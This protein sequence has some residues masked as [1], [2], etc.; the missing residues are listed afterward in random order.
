LDFRIHSHLTGL[1]TVTA[2]RAHH[3]EG[4]ATPAGSHRLDVVDF[5]ERTGKGLKPEQIVEPG[6]AQQFVDLV[7]RVKGGVPIKD[8]F[9]QF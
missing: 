6:G 3:D 7:S 9:R 8:A 5:A 2:P 1:I 4:A